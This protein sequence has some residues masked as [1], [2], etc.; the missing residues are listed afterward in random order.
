MPGSDDE[1]DTN[2]VPTRYS[3][4]RGFQ[5]DPI[6]EFSPRLN[7]NDSS[8]TG[9]KYVYESILFLWLQAWSEFIDKNPGDFPNFES[10][11]CTLVQ[12]FEHSQLLLP[13]FL[14]SFSFR[15]SVEVQEPS[16]DNAY[17]KAILDCQHMSALKQLVEIL[18]RSLM[19]Q[20][21]SQSKSPSIGKRNCSLLQAL[22]SSELILDF[23]VGLFAL[24]HPEHLRSLL[25][26]YFKT[27][28]DCEEH[29]KENSN[30]MLEFHWTEESIR[31]VKCSRQ[32][33][34]RAGKCLKKC[35]FLPLA[36]AIFLNAVDP[37]ESS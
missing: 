20:A 19:G 10:D 28:R 22:A 36:W 11:S 30:G 31:R 21:L 9:G 15:H 6:L 37:L 5:G 7:K 18:A 8:I 2:A 32:L 29:T 17:T 24:L 13:L 12:F 25:E 33:R 14:K 16:D 26:K 23:F 27:L 4:F 34:L 3:A 1:N 35:S